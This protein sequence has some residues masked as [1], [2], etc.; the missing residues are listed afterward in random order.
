MTD[1][2]NKVDEVMDE[3]EVI[4]EE[5]KEEAVDMAKDVKKVIEVEEKED[6]FRLSPLGVLKFALIATAGVGTGWFAK[7]I[8]D[9]R[10]SRKN[11]AAVSGYVADATPAPEPVE[12]FDYSQ[13]EF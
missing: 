10:K 12:E 7:T 3:V 5:V 9:D 4:I 2:T 6:K 8:Y 13:V 1:A 11:T